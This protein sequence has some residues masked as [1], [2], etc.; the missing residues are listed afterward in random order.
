MLFLYRLVT[1][2]SAPLLHYLLKRRIRAGKEDKK[3]ISERKGIASIPRPNGIV[4]WL[5]AASVGETQSAL[6]LVN[7]L[8]ERLPTANILVTSGTVTSATLMKQKLPPR[9]IH[10]YIP[11]DHPVWVS[12]FL[13]HWKPEMVLWMESELWPN[14]LKAIKTLDIPAFLMNVLLLCILLVLI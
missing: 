2:L 7:K 4:I 8:L 10:Q 12:K 14:I 5:H 6:I 1:Y 11:L 9:A 13:N 3:R